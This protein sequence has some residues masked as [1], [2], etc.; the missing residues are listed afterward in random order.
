[1]HQG[2]LVLQKFS[3]YQ[4]SSK[5]LLQIWNHAASRFQIK[6]SRDGEVASITF[7]SPVVT[8]WAL[9]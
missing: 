5:I 2:M 3:G 6:N 1:M 7:E 4:D 9:V 8:L